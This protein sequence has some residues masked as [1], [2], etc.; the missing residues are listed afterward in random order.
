MLKDYKKQYEKL[1]E[2]KNLKGK[3]ALE[4]V[5]QNGY[6]LR[7]VAEQTEEICLEAVKQNGD[8]LRY[9]A[10]QTEEIC[11]EAVKQDGYALQYVAEQTE[12]ICLE[13]VKQNRDALQYVDSKFFAEEKSE[14]FKE[15]DS[16]KE[17]FFSEVDDLL[18]K[19]KI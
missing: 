16:V 1:S 6:A 12:E 3:E 7:Y 13:A 18:N 4:A 5:K 17:K 15:L 2:K 8:A 9:V 11:L 14:I 10:E 19:I